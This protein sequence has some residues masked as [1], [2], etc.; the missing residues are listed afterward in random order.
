[1]KRMLPC[2]ILLLALGCA[3]PQQPALEQI[4]VAA[5]ELATPAIS[6][7]PLLSATP[8]NPPTPAPT[9]TPEPKIF[10]A[11]T[12]SATIGWI[13]DPQH[14]AAKYP[15]TYDSMTRFLLDERER[16]NL[17]YVVCTGD[18]VN[19]FEDETQWQ[20]ASEA[21]STLDGS[22]P[23][24]VLGG[25]HDVRRATA[26]GYD[27]YWNY[28]GK[29]RFLQNG[30]F[31]MDFENNR[32]HCDLVSIGQ[33]DFVFVYMTL[34]PDDAARAFVK[35]CFD[36]YPDRIGVLCLHDYVDGEMNL[37]KDG[38]RFYESVI[39]STDNLYL[40]LCGH[41]YGVNHRLDKFPAASG[42][43]RQALTLL[44]NYQAAAEGGRGYLSL[45][46]INQD[47]GVLD[48][49]NY[50]P[51][52]EDV[53]LFDTAGERTKNYPKNRV[54]ESVTLPLPWKAS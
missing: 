17:A 5:M 26:G 53:D 52:T 10:D 31:E 24:G 30:C 14:Y 36:A 44:Q 11:P 27:A 39:Q 37:T 8:T 32:G 7:T 45:L 21:F 50:S 34:R 29:N 48:I 18:L 38:E 13:S 46:R 1:M 20:V 3:V 33:T 42:G 40:V 2:F 25:N 54:V 4:E 15:E 16:L 47:A 41:R 19:D 43:E 23:Y 6:D 49:L 12:G 9:P 22:I 35:S 51:V 28:F